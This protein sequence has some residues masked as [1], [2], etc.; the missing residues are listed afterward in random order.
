MKRLL[1]A[2][3]LIALSLLS[4]CSSS[5]KSNIKV[6]LCLPTNESL[7]KVDAPES[8]FTSKKEVKNWAND[9]IKKKGELDLL[10]KL[11]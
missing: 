10:S 1:L 5:P 6:F 3:L 7:T 8:S 2:P 11:F 4:S 9:L